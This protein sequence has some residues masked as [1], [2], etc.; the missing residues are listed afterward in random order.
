V[1]LPAPAVRA[2]LADRVVAPTV[3]AAAPAL[4]RQADVPPVLLSVTHVGLTF[5]ALPTTPDGGVEI[6]MYANGPV[7]IGIGVSALT[8]LRDT[9][10]LRTLPAFTADVSQG[11]LH[12][13]LRRGATSME[14]RGTVRG[15][16][17]TAVGAT[18]RHF[19]FDKGGT[20]VRLVG[21]PAGQTPGEAASRAR[22]PR[23][24]TMTPVSTTD[25]LLADSVAARKAVLEL[26]RVKMLT[27][28]EPT[29]VLMQ[30]VN[31]Q[32]AALDR[33]LATVPPRAQARALGDVLLML[34]RR[35]AGLKVELAQLEAK[36]ESFS[37]MVQ[38][39]KQE[40]V[41]LDA[42]RAEIRQ[43]QRTR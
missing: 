40:I 3:L 1:A 38:E 32:L 12:V 8:P 37:P 13:E 26:R 21:G 11:D 2:R 33:T 17:A 4:V 19:A 34:D 39:A 27:K 25:A 42:R 6:V 35:E 43:Q 7:Q 36:Y 41:L 5:A 18:G 31:G 30:E 20:G 28:Y 10:R 16:P 29:G 14:L 23:A 9:L 22:N 15:G 24:S